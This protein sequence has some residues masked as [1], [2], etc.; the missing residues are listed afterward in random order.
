MQSAM[1]YLANKGFDETRLNAELLLAHALQ[2]QRIQIYTNFD[3]PLHVHEVALFRSFFERRLQHEPLQYIVGTTNFMGLQFSVK[4]G[5]LIPR[6]E[7]ETLIEQMVLECKNLLREKRIDVLEIGTGSGNIAVSIAKYIKNA[8]ITTVDISETALGIA[9][10]NALF[11]HV[12]DRI[13]FIHA[14]VFRPIDIIKTK[15]YEILVSNPPYVA[16]QE[17][18]TL[19]PEIFQYEPHEAVTDHAD[20]LTFYKRIA[21]IS[22][23]LLTDD[24]IVMVE[25]GCGQAE[26]VQKILNQSAFQEISIIKDLQS[27]P[28]VLCGYR[29]TASLTG[30]FFSIN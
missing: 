14:D 24:G 19:Q 28:R 1:Q 10:E 25:V 27:V 17:W 26:S 9:R 23:D 22:S 2:L 20:G 21:E 30:A 16:E 29:K 7:T 15:K 18:R 12:E 6:P 8:Y 4:Q 3:K 5:V 13:D 11:H